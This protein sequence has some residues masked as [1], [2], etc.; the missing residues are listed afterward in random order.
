MNME[1]SDYLEGLAYSNPDSPDME[2]VSAAYQHDLDSHSGY[3]DQVADAYDQRRMNWVN[4]TLDQRKHSLDAKPWRFASD[5][6]VP[7]I[8]PRINA[9][10]AI[11]MNA[12][13]SGQISANPIGSE[14]AEESAVRSKFVRWMIDCWIPNAYDN[15]E[16]SIQNMF[17]KGI[18]ATWCGW[19]KSKRVHKEQFDLE[20]LAEVAPELAEIFA[21]PEREDEVIEI[22][23]QQFE[24]VNPKRAKKALKQLRETGV[25]EI[26]VV[27]GDINRPTLVSKCPRADIILPQYAM[28]VRDLDRAHIRHFMSIQDL[29]SAA[30]SQGWDE[31]WV[32]SVIE[33]NMGMTQQDIEGPYGSRDAYQANQTATLF[34]LGNRDADDL[35]EIVETL[36]RQVD[37]EDGAIGFYRTIW[38]PKRNRNDKEGGYAIHELLNGWDEFPI[39][40]T[41]MSRDSKRIYDQRNACDLLRGNQR[42]Q[43]V[44]R[45]AFV[46]QMSIAMNPPRTHPAARPPTP[47]GA[48][49]DMPTRRGEENLYRTLEIPETSDNGMRFSEYLDE[50]ADKIMG[51]KANDPISAARQQYYVNR[52]LVHVSECARLAYKSFQRFYEGPDIHFRV[53]N[54][55]DPQQFN[56]GSQDED[57]DVKLYYDVRNMDN[58]F[59]KDSLKSMMELK[60]ADIGGDLDS[61]E[62]MRIAALMIVPQYAD[63]ILRPVEEAQADIQK[64]VAED[65][66]MIWAGNSLNA[67]PTGAQLALQYIEGYQQK[68]S[69]QKRLAEDPEY[70]QSFGAY[71]QQYQFQIQQQQNAATGR[72]GTEQQDITPNQ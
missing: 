16:M 21:D 69:I 67:R 12:V 15:I 9:L 68:E 47:W 45:D 55:P 28:D 64:N 72:L 49:A 54:S 23:S 35:V 17:E 39:S 56:S 6:E 27:K 3:A 57:L 1:N 2:S 70:A 24:S 51:L 37:K 61:T 66:T 53:T 58:E 43:K 18:A 36:T 8:D 71:V 63:R 60:A 32:E 62:I 31:E 11:C 33:E 46:D 7:V 5:V 14:D 30:A 41:T 20:Q 29:T 50:E 4:K 48:G 25:A 65:L 26:P 44:T 42:L 38:C 40:I 22:L 59:V 13:R 19:E 34:N 10:V 52:A